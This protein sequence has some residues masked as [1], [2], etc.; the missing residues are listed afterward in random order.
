MLV[1]VVVVGQQG[2][3]QRRQ[4]DRVCTNAILVAGVVD[5][6]TTTTIIII[7]IIEIKPQ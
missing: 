6:I 7:V 2:D 5:L 3:L 1:V 4:V